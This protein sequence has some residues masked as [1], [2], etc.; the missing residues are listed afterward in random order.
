MTEA[1]A[2]HNE[3]Q[4][5]TAA[6]PAIQR[7]FLPDAE[8][9]LISGFLTSDESSQLRSQLAALDW[10]QP[11]IRL[12]GRS[13]AIPRRQ[14]WMGD[15][16]CSY[17]YSGVTFQPEPWQAGLEQLCDRLVRHTGHPLNAVL[18][19]HYQHGEH[20]MG[21]HSDDEP[22]LGQD[23]V[24]LSLSLGQTRRFDLKHKQLNT[25]L[26]LELKDG[27]L[28]VMGGTCQRFWQHR[29]PKQIRL[30]AER[31]NLTFRYLLP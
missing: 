27:D 7:Y 1:Q 22:E 14:I 15:P 6:V 24:I 21:W 12:Y 4:V 10:Q 3:R 5:V 19:N 16:H 11:H 20:H 2:G 18:L 13:V 29:V 8:V 26:S 9:Y 31:F 30:D 23:P 17:R 28:L 25:Q